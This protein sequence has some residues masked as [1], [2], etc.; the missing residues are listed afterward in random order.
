MNFTSKEK[1]IHKDNRERARQADYEKV[2]KE[3][4]AV[5]TWSATH[6]PDYGTRPIESHKICLCC[7]KEWP[8]NTERTHCDCRAGGFLY[9]AGKVYQKRV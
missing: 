8:M 5:K 4:Q 1:E 3:G 9:G 6:K 2:Q 7:R